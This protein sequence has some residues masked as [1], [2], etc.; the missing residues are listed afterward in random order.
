MGSDPSQIRTFA[1]RELTRYIERM[2]GQKI[3][4][5]TAAAHRIYIGEIP[6][7]LPAQ[8]LTK[9]RED[10]GTLSRDGFIVRKVGG[11]VIVMGKGDRGELY[12][13][14]AFL[15]HLG[16]RWF[17]PGKEHEVVPRR[18]INWSQPLN[19]VESPTFAER[20]LFYW[21]HN[22]TKFEDWIDFSAKARLNRIAIHYTL[23]ARDWY[24]NA[25]ERALPELQKRGMT[26]Q[27]D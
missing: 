10:S 6:T 22:Y 24:I 23:P 12:G 2:A 17:F 13:C 7:G 20:T 18:G 9:L 4:K 1:A 19:I 8:A 15:E 25:R 21:P 5:G 27:D 14:Y 3:Q 11:D 16:V 26:K